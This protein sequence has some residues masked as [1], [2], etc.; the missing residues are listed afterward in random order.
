MKE[1]ISPMRRHNRKIMMMYI[2][3]FQTG[4]KI[5]ED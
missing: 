5:K 3:L 1:E 2:S 4:G